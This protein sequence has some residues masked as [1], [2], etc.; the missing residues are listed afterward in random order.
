M[1]L[2]KRVQGAH[3]SIV[4]YIAALREL[5]ATCEFPNADD[6]ISDRLVEH[7]TPHKGETAV[8]SKP[9]AS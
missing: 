9:D 1:R 8:K 5:A 6:M 2:G 7:V 3:E 4:Q